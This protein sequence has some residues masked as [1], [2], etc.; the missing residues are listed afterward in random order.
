[1]AIVVDMSGTAAKPAGPDIAGWASDQRVFI[2]SVMADLA[3]ERCAVAAAVE[4]F[5]STPVWFEEFGGRDDDAQAAYLAEVKS[6]S[7]Y[8]AILR[9]NYGRLLPTRLSATHE[10]YREA[11]RSGLRISAWVHADEDFQGD[12][13]TFVEEIQQF[14][15]TGRFTGPEDLA[16]GVSGRLA[17]IAAEELSPWCKLEDVVFRARRITDTGNAIVVRAVV[18]NAVLA[19]LEALRPGSWSGARETRLTF[20]G[21]SHAIRVMKVTTTTSSTRTTDVEIELERTPGGAAHGLT[22]SVGLNGATYT[23]D[24]ITELSLKGALFGEKAPRSLLSIGGSIGDPLADMPAAPLSVD[25]YRAVLNLLVT[26]ALV[27]SGRCT[28]VVRVQVA[29]P[30]PEGRRVRVEWVARPDRNAGPDV[31]VVDGY[32][33]T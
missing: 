30:G 21:R 14:H 29:P 7:V 19:H 24:D 11:E 27:S 16:K 12:Q 2:S 23:A 18:G 1:M 8:V 22:V 15:T 10:E 20:A 6:S 13:H 25:L 28:R 32:I 3:E 4:G 31:R 9:R 17:G 5:G 26:E 33:R